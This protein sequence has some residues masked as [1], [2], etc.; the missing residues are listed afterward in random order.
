MDEAEA[1]KI[2]MVQYGSGY[3]L[4]CNYNLHTSED[5]FN[6]EAWDRLYLKSM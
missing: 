6:G 5:E 1:S 4:S 3:I 2:P